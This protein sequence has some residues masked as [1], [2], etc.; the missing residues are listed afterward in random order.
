MV[1][2]AREYVEHLR[3]RA[4]LMAE[5]LAMLQQFISAYDQLWERGIRPKTEDDLSFPRGIRQVLREA[6]GPLTDNEIWRRMVTIGV[7]S[8]AKRPVN[9]ISLHAK[10]MDNVV[11]VAPHTFQWVDEEPVAE[12][13]ENTTATL[14]VTK[15][16]KERGYFHLPQRFTADIVDGDLTLEL[17]TPLN[18]RGTVTQEAVGSVVHSTRWGRLRRVRGRMA[19]KQWFKPFGVGD[20]Y[21][22][23][24]VE[25]RR[26]RLEPVQTQFSV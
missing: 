16:N 12:E 22:V 8:N 18:G 21:K 24:L 14:Q 20:S 7:R 26:L 19:L 23:S 25:P 5:E 6:S 13:P 2:T 15:T 17:V 4:E 1:E 10:T 9:Y 11:E 3:G